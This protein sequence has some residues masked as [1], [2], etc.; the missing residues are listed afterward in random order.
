MNRKILYAVGDRLLRYVY[1]NPRRNLVKLVKVGKLVAGKMFPPS[2]FTK[3]IEI[4]EDED[5][6]W[7]QF[8]FRGLDEVDPALFRRIA[9]TFA[10]DLGYFGTKA[11]RA[12]RE[13]E[14]CNIPW[15]VLMDP[16]SA[17]NRHCK[18]CWAAEYGHKSNLTL[19]EMRRIVRE[20]KAL[21]THF[22]MYTG[23]EPLVRKADILKLAEKHNDVQ[24]AI[25]T[26]STL[27]DEPF[28][29]EVQRLG[30]IAFMLSIEGTPETND[31]RR[32]EGHYAAVMRAMDLLK[33]LNIPVVLQ[34][35]RHRSTTYSNLTGDYEGT[36]L[37][38]ARFF[39]ERLFRNFAF[40]GVK[41]VVWSDE[42]CKGYRGEV[43]RI[44]G[45]FHAFETGK[46]SEKSREVLG[47]WLRELPKPV[48][49]FCCDDAHA[50][51][52]SEICKM[53]NIPIPEDVSLLGV[54]NDELICNIS[55][56]PI[57][58]I[59]LEVEKGGYAVGKL[60]HRQIRKEFVGPFN[61][62][63]N[64]IRIELR[65]STEKH[66]I[67]D[68]Y[69][70]RIVKYIERHIAADLTIDAIIGQIPLSRRNIELKFKRV[71]NTS[72]YQYVLKCRVKRFANLLLTTDLPLAE[73]AGEAG[74]RDCNNI[75]RIFKKFMG[76]SPIE[77]RQRRSAG[78]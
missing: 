46:D 45:T 1:K 25:Y 15:V 4:I 30:N 57:S 18:G 35:Y 12:N 39:A 67:E 40:F 60:L 17:C 21:G 49:L 54:D 47:R 53:E 78:K 11:L 27:I 52:I 24:F 72:I 10:I 29:Q 37:M 38:A 55:D 13:K 5:N 2:T 63:I 50:L 44:G 64:P 74:F 59:E 6:V 14:H 69:V 31:A 28:C 75:S 20:C 33:E 51:I 68:P 22:F 16:T 41:G 48:A 23:G 71:M 36:G 62:V 3:P 9:L 76:C 43:E 19:D 32:G 42:R 65:Q 70:L 66:N 56:P 34:N 58:S 7:H 61:V 8:L 73:I 26:N 77:Y